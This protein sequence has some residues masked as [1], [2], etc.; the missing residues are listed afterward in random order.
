MNRNFLLLLLSSFSLVATYRSAELLKKYETHLE[1]GTYDH[2]NWQKFSVLPKSRY[3]TFLKAFELFEQNNGKVI[4][5][6][7]TTHSFVHGGLEGCD[8]NDIKY[9]TPDQTERWD[10]GA[11]CFT[12]MAAE[13]LAHCNPTIHTIDTDALAIRRCR[14]MTD[15][16]QKS[17]G[18]H[19]T[20]SEAFLRSCE[21]RSID[22][23]YLDTG[24]MNPIEPTAQLQLREAKLIVER[25][26]LT[27]NGIILIDDVRNQNV[28]NDT[29]GMGKSR[30]AIPYLLAQGFEIIADEYQVMMRKRK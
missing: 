22:L 24:Y 14:I 28:Q 6:L 3:H 2:Q 1:K 4:V 30:H 18:Y 20:S 11:G 16:Y 29:S 5:E 10:W 27:K 19:R 8:S 23:I 12:I 26:L 9:W 25:D 13:C 15:A 17:I 7:G 21:P